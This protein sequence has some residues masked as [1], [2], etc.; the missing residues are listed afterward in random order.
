MKN[1]LGKT[2]LPLIKMS[3]CPPST[4]LAQAALWVLKA[5]CHPPHCCCSV[6]VVGSYRGL[7]FEPGLCACL[8]GRVLL[9]VQ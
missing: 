5:R 2:P 3:F 9:L 1:Y 6:Q 4:K 8:A 7:C